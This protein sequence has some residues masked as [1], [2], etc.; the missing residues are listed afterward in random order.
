LLF[1][2]PVIA[3]FLADDLFWFKN[4]PRHGCHP[5]MHQQGVLTIDL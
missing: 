1:H 2:S 3:L 5:T 4:G